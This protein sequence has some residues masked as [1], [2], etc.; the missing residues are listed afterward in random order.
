MWFKRK[1]KKTKTKKRKRRRRRRRR[2]RKK[3]IKSLSILLSCTQLSL[4]IYRWIH[5][6]AS[7][8]PFHPL[9][10]HKPPP[11]LP[12]QL[13]LLLPKRVFFIIIII[14][15]IF[16]FFYFLL[17]S[18]FSFFFWGGGGEG[19]GG[20]KDGTNQISCMVSIKTNESNWKLTPLVTS[21]P[22]RGKWPL[23]TRLHEQRFIST[24]A[25]DSQ[26]S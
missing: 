9:L 24:V 12:F 7:I 18:W 22:G 4:N 1:K 26:S 11:L 13:L 16:F 15:I 3:K 2:R 23:I 20:I 25:R 10:L 21:P 14:I 17:H 6:G 5:H 8:H 19:G